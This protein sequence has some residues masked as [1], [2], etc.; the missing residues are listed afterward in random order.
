[1][2]RNT[3]INEIGEW[4]IDQALAQPEEQGAQKACEP[5]TFEE[6]PEDIAVVKA[7][8]TFKTEHA[9][10][11]ELSTGQPVACS[12]KP[13]ALSTKNMTCWVVHSGDDH[14]DLPLLQNLNFQVLNDE[15]WFDYGNAH[16]NGHRL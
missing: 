8:N 1:M 10:E 16:K 13:T 2:Q 9:D 7:V 6:L 11:P 4:L 3:L 15:R 12:T 14:G 5:V